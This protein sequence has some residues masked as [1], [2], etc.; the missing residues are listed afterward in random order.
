MIKRVDFPSI[1]KPGGRPVEGKG[2]NPERSKVNVATRKV[3]RLNFNIELLE[4]LCN[5]STKP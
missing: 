3:S 5:L 1:G 2:N 4:L